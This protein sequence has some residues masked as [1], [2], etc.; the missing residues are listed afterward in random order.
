MTVTPMLGSAACAAAFFDGLK[1]CRFVA[2]WIDRFGDVSAELSICSS[3]GVARALD[4]RKARPSRSGTTTC[5]GKR[6]RA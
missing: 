2:A 4:T 6:T 5:D 3:R 1:A